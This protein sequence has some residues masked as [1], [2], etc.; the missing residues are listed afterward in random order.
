MGIKLLWLG[1][2]IITAFDKVF[3]IPA[4]QIVGSVIMI[5]GC[6]LMIIDR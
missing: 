4:G 5:I 3:P 2:T 1:L 6:L